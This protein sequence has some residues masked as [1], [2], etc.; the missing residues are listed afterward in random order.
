[1]YEIKN[2]NKKMNKIRYFNELCMQIDH[3]G[4][5]FGHKILAIN[6][7]ITYFIWGGGRINYNYMT[8]V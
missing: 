1:M 3:I 5:L 6:S 2:V 8:K 4:A 7:N